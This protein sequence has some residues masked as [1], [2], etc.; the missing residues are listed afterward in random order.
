MR[1][2]LLLPTLFDVAVLLAAVP[3]RLL[4]SWLRF[5]K[6]C[7]DMIYVA[8]WLVRTSGCLRNSPQEPQA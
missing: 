1:L 6:T 7:T 3:V 4:R 2:T 5:G 8:S